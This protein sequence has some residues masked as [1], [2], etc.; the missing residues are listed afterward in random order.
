MRVMQEM[1]VITKL[2]TKGF[3]EFWDMQQIFFGG[4]EVFVRKAF[5]GGFVVELVFC[6]AVGRWQPGNSRLRAYGEVAHGGVFGDF[7]D[8]LFDVAAVCVAVDHDA[9]AALSADKV[10]KRS[11]ESFAFDVPESDVDGAD[12][13][14]G[15]GA[16]APVSAAIK[17]LPDIF[18]LKRIAADQAGN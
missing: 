10:V 3:E 13:G 5:F 18:G 6:N 4:P 15:H 17:I 9:V 16:A 14:H 1:N 2:Q 12:G 8:G 7:I 11:V